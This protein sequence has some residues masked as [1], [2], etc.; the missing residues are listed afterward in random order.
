MTDC[1]SVCFALRLLENK[2]GCHICPGNGV[3]W[4]YTC[5]PG[6][7]LIRVLAGDFTRI[8]E[9]DGNS[10]CFVCTQVSFSDRYQE[11]RRITIP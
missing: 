10:P 9:Y 8:V 5:R 3:K 1:G 6:S 7:C 11:P 4:V 2:R